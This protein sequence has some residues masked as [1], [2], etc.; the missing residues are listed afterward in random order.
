MRFIKIPAYLT[1]LILCVFIVLSGT[2][3]ASAA[4]L[5]DTGQTKCY[6]NTE[7]ITCP[8]PG[9]PFYGQDGNYLINPPSYTRLDENGNPLPDIAVTWTTVRDNLTGLIWEVKTDDGSIHDKDNVYR[10]PTGISDF[11]INVNDSNFGGYSDWRIPSIKEVS[12]II[13]LGKP[14]QITTINEIYFPNCINGIY[15]SDNPLF[16]Y[17]VYAWAAY[18][19]RGSIDFRPLSY[20]RYVRCVRGEQQSGNEFIDN[21]DGTVSDRSTGLMWQQ[22]TAKETTSSISVSKNYSPKVVRQ[23]PYAINDAPVVTTGS[24]SSVTSVSATLNGTVNP[25]GLNTDFYFEYD[26]SLSFGSTTTR[27]AVGNGTNAIPVSASLTGLQRETYYYRIVAINSAG[28]SFGVNKTVTTLTPGYYNWEE[29]LSYCENLTLGGYEDWRLP[30]RI[31]LQSIVDYGTSGPAINTDYFPDTLPLLYRSSTPYESY[32]TTDVWSIDFGH[33]NS[34]NNRKEYKYVYTRCVRGGQAG[35]VLPTITTTAISSISSTSA[36]SG[37]NVTSEGGAI[38][39]AR[40]ACW[41]SSANPT[42]SNNKTTDGSRTGTYIS[43]ITGLS[44]ETL[45]HVRAYATN[46]F[47]TAYGSDVNFTTSSS[48]YVNSNGYCG[49]KTICHSTIQAAIEAASTGTVILIADGTYDE[50]ITLNA[51]R[52]LTLQGGWDS[53]FENQTGTTILRNAPNAPQGSLTLQMVTIKP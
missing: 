45:Y 12:T 11:A 19:S 8:Q 35:A 31:E 36:S 47:G 24:A 23:G 41:G 34:S 25:N 49:G 27:T 30:N 9:E 15:W 6:N 10:W 20:S 48:R 2:D 38:V 40:G 21:G 46:S 53:T 26:T 42:T 37:G 4:P 1:V 13:N 5:P 52:T 17:D 43:S 39:T 14:D 28:T 7:E 50:D 51:D 3:N 32:T 22:V 44:S 33:G 29:A 18:F 16:N